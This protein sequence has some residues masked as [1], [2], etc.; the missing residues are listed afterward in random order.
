M[1]A[2][3]SSLRSPAAQRLRPFVDPAGDELGLLAY[4]QQRP[5]GV[6]LEGLVR[7]FRRDQGP[8]LLLVKC[9]DF[10]EAVGFDA[11]LLVEH[12]ALNP[13]GSTAEHKAPRAGFPKANL[14]AMLRR[15]TDEAGLAVVS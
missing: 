3:L 13:M 7:R 10:Y 15:L 8:R 14:R 5:R 2:S 4:P 1:E 6:L 9:G 11:V 12:L